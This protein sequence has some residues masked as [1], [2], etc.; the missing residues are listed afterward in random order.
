MVREESVGFNTLNLPS[1]RLLAADANTLFECNSI[2]LQ[3]S[4]E[5]MLENPPFSES[6]YLTPS[7]STLFLSGT[8]SGRDVDSLDELRDREQHLHERLLDMPER[9]DGEKV[10]SLQI[11]LGPPQSESLS[12]LL[13]TAVYLNSNGTKWGYPAPIMSPIMLWIAR[14]IPFESMKMLFQAKVPTVEAFKYELLQAGLFAGNFSLTKNLLDMDRRLKRFL[15]GSKK[16]LEFTINA[17]KIEVV[18]LLVQ[19]IGDVRRFETEHSF[20]LLSYCNS[21]PVAQLLVAAG[22]H[23]QPHAL[24][25]AVYLHNT[26]MIKF[27]ICAGTYLNTA[28]GPYDGQIKGVEA[29]MVAVYK[30]DVELLK[31]L[32]E[33]NVN[34]NQVSKRLHGLFSGRTALQ[35]AATKAHIEIVEILLNNG[36]DVNAPAYG[37]VGHTALQAAVENA[38][39][40][41]VEL[42]LNRGAIVDAPGT[43]SKY[44]RTALLA[45]AEKKS[46]TLIEMLLKFKANPNSPSFGYY[47]TTVLEAA[48]GLQ[49]DRPTIL[50]LEAAASNLKHQPLCTD[51]HLKSRYMRVQLLHAIRKA[52]LTRIKQ[53][54]AAGVEIDLKPVND[55]NSTYVQH[56]HR[57]RSTIFHSAIMFP[58]IWSSEV[59]KFLFQY[60]NS[61]T[62][63]LLDSDLEPLLHT[64]IYWRRFEIT[65]FLLDIVGVD[66]NYIDVIK[67]TLEPSEYDRFD[68]RVTGIF[69]AVEQGN[70]EMVQLL[71]C[72]GAGINPL[73][74]DQPDLL[75]VSLDRFHYHIARYLLDCGMDSNNPATRYNE[76]TTLCLAIKGCSREFLEYIVAKGARVD[77]RP[78]TNKQT[79]LQVAVDYGRLD[80]VQVLLDYNADA[81]AAPPKNGRTALQ[82][83]AAKGYLRIAQLLLDR[84]ADVNMVGQ[85]FSTTAL[86]EAALRCQLDMVQ[87]L[88]NAGADK[89]LPLNK[90][91]LRPLR[92]AKEC[93]YSPNLGV[94]AVL[95]CY[96]K[97]AIEQLNSLRI[98][99]MVGSESDDEDESDYGDEAESSIADE[100]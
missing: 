81:N 15:L 3:E 68:F 14:N 30:H 58:K 23:V 46:N 22:A 60:T 40:G 80:L 27:L 78:D 1:P 26:E 52:D 21:V 85:Y 5:N 64:A 79:A 87:L 10:K 72:R 59:F 86:E 32:L 66:I 42:L 90:R 12:F 97:E 41:T 73:S 56:A 84:G 67:S 83:T 50:S 76:A 36:A 91:F 11:L 94:I 13:T 38:D 99:E 25:N 34:V 49:L 48:R 77:N 55:T 18:D 82:L 98:L 51:K 70:L 74:Q 92:L 33:K 47:G 2:G 45:A 17:D 31:L 6:T 69:H 19:L 89:H 61:S 43:T 65:E 93:K 4:P 37:D 9:T 100:E 16:L 24:R 75:Q 54:V 8:L 7:L 35:V 57:R 96:R 62:L 39:I 28:D 20:Y 53:L 88:I 44:P 71:R 63:Q 29:L 95:E